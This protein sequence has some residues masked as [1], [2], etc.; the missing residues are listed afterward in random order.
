MDKPYENP[1][2]G[3]ETRADMN[4][5]AIGVIWEIVGHAN[6]SDAEKVREI[7]GMLG[8]LERRKRNL[9]T[10][11]PS[12]PTESPREIYHPYLSTETL[13]LEPFAEGK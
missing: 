2:Y 10:K 13:K 5:F 9:D 7:F 8:E 6:T 12:A 3:L 1:W 4:S 11:K